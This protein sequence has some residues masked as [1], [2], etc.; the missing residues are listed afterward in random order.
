[1]SEH[2]EHRPEGRVSRWAAG[3]VLVRP[4]EGPL[5]LL[6]GGYFF[7]LLLGYYLLRPMRETFGI[8]RGAD[9]LPWLMSGTLVAMLAV[10]PLFGAL[11]SRFPRRRFIPGATRVFC[12][13][14]VVFFLA[15]V[16]SS[17][18][19]SPWLGYTFYVWLS[20]FNLFVV[21]L[22]WGFMTDL[23]TE[24]QGRRL[25]GIVALG[26]SAGAI[27][28][29]WV[30]AA[31]SSGI[32]LGA[33]QLQAGTPVLLLFAALVLEGTVWCVHGLCDRRGL[34]DRAG[35]ARE[36]G[37][38]ALEG[39]RLLGSSP[40]LRLMAAY[41]LLFTITSTLLYLEQ[42]RIVAK[43]FSGT[44]ARTAAFARLDL[45]TN[46]LTLGTQLLFTGRIL[47]R[48]GIGIVLCLLP[49]LTLG[50][51]AAL[52]LW[53]SF[54]T[55]GAVMVARRGL[56][57]AVDRPARELLYIPLGPGEK[58]KSKPFIDTFV[59]RTGD[60]AGAW[61]PT[62]LARLGAGFAPAALVLSALWLGSG[63]W[64]GKWAG[65]MLGKDAE[66]P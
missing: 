9:N 15:L 48:I 47:R 50:G 31:L 66:A 42:G 39:L 13:T 21:S 53:P 38:G 12:A 25:F 6:S 24:E 59:Y 41:L 52:A 18:R 44:A 63:A 35:E 7:L 64:L 58:Y 36:P 33:L 3:L 8:A 54:V 37:P 26:G 11:V 19:P 30:A 45:W 2:P 29:A 17:G 62:L 60:I 34:G 4:G 57:H 51:F 27:T 23:F 40:Y 49:L 65:R 32:H 14:I 5:L 46:L 56:H 28:G 1:M 16:L 10:N 22:F 55:L 20:V 43:T 61:I